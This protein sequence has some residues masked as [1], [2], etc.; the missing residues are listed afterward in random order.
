MTRVLIFLALLQILAIDQAANAQNS[1]PAQTFPSLGM[2]A[3]Q[4]NHDY[5]NAAFISRAAISDIVIMNLWNGW[6]DPG[7]RLNSLQVL[8]AINGAST[9]NTLS[10]GYMIPEQSEDYSAY[11]AWLSQV[12]SANWWLRTSFPSGA[13]VSDSNVG[14]S[15][16]WLNVLVGGA[17]GIGGRTYDQYMADYVVDFYYNGDAAGLATDGSDPVNPLWAGMYQDSLY[18]CFTTNADYARTG[19]SNSGSCAQ[20]AAGQ[21]AVTQ[22]VQADKPGSLAFGNLSECQNPAHCPMIQAGYGG[23]LDGGDLENMV[24]STGS[25]ENQGL[26]LLL[27]AYQNQ[28]GLLNSKQ[29]GVFTAYNITSNG[30][31]QIN[32]NVPYQAARNALAICMV[33]GNARCDLQSNT[34]SIDA[35]AALWFDEDAVNRAT[36][37]PCV[38]PGT[39][40]AA[41]IGYLGAAVDP[42][43]TTAHQGCYWRRRFQYGEVWWSPASCSAGTIS[44]GYT[45]NFIAGVQAPSFNT[46]GSGS[47]HPISSRD[48]I[49]VLYQNTAAAPAPALTGASVPNP[50]AGVSITK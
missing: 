47:T 45:V 12:N 23:Q 38:T 50:P 25:I 16:Y 41:N 48:G 21:L 28:M 40:C 49:I 15:G 14:G 5:G 7:T 30:E 42:P 29:L 22:R 31:D 32:T 10:I 43:Q 36:Q 9:R 18:G 20:W 4:D 1:L 27:L 26:A 44:F 6:R 3:I 35:N 24:G 11:P 33:L 17:T 13:Q 46:G 8:Q 2:Y 37:A 19:S 34:G 39:A